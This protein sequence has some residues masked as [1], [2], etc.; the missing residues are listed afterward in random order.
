MACH[1]C[2]LAAA[3]TLLDKHSPVGRPG[4]PAGAI[5]GGEHDNCKPLLLPE[6]LRSRQCDDFEPK[7]CAGN[8]RGSLVLA[9]REDRHEVSL[10]LCLLLELSSDP[11][12]HA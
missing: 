1:F 4:G 2:N 10:C 11:D 5:N 6:D 8:A 12:G 3:P 7:L 9:F